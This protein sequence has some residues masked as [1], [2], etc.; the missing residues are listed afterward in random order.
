MPLGSFG[1]GVVRVSAFKL[2]EQPQPQA[3]LHSVYT[4][5]GLPQRSGCAGV[6]TVVGWDCVYSLEG[7]GR[8][9]SCPPFPPCGAGSKGSLSE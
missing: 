4:A 9:G 2:D 3:G 1:G 8:R 7:H 6:R 5:P